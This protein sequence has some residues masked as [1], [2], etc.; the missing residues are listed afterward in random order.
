MPSNRYEQAGL[1]SSIAANN[2][3]PQFGDGI[4]DR[5]R[6]IILFLVMALV[7]AT[8]AVIVILMLYRAALSEERKRLVETAQSQARLIEA[9]ARFNAQY[10]TDFSSGLII[11][12]FKHAFPDDREGQREVSIAMHKTKDKKIQLVIQDNGQGLPADL[13]LKNINSLGLKLVSLLAEDQLEGELT[14]TRQNGACFQICFPFS[15]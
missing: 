3:S 12:A 4:N 15:S 11:N 5:Q 14:V 2:L 13:D 7:T 9:V 1:P 10:H 6:R 8:V